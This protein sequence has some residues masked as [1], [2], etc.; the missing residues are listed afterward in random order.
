MVILNVSLVLEIKY[1]MFEKWE[2]NVGKRNSK[3]FH[4]FKIRVSAGNRERS[5][6]CDI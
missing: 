4:D 2:E 6:D 1:K 3:T 5:A